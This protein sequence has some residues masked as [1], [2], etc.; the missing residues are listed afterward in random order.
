MMARAYRSELR[1][2]QLRETRTRILD[3]V[4]EVLAEGV[5]TLSIP[6]VAEQAGVSVGT[7]YRHFGDKSGLLKALLSHAG[8]RTGT[9]IEGIPTTLDELNDVVRKVFNHFESADDLLKAALASRIGHEARMEWTEWRVQGTKDALLQLV[10]G[11]TPE[12]A[13]HMSKAVLIMITSD[14]YRQWRERFGLDPDGAAD[15]VMWVIKT[16]LRGVEP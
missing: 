1:E 5:E 12:D 14:T 7:V 3:A 16:L 8:E 11:M 2:T 10:P 6:A 13:E 9:V 4:V 15:E